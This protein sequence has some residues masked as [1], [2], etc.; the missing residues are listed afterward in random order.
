MSSHLVYSN[1]DPAKVLILH[2]VDGSLKSLLI[3]NR[4]FFLFFPSNYLLAKP[5]HLSCGMS[6]W[7]HLT[8]S[9]SL[10]L[11]VHWSLGLNLDL[12]QVQVC[13]QEYTMD[14]TYGLPSTSYQRHVCQNVPLL[15]ML[16]W[17]HGVKG[18]LPGASVTQSLSA[19]H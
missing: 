11:S 17:V 1:Q 7:Y 10:V 13:R 2:L 8:H 3:Y 9:L 18:Y 14:G 6:L 4:P 16:R 19:L 5:G 12:I 15:V